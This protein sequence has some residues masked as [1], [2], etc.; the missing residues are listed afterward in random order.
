MTLI[1]KKK[2]S[3]KEI[4]TPQPQVHTTRRKQTSKEKGIFLGNSNFDQDF[5]DVEKEGKATLTKKYYSCYSPV[6]TPREENK[7]LFPLE[8]NA[9]L[10]A[11]E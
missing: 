8:D 4:W 10:A 7:E 5:N 3:K 6:Y 1:K 11:A 9:F 2:E